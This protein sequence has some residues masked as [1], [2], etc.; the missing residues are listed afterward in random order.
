MQ[1]QIPRGPD[2]LYCPTWKKKMSTVCHT[3]PLWVRLAGKN[4]NTGE[5]MEGWH[6]SMQVGPILVLSQADQLR[7]VSNEIEALRNEIAKQIAAMTETQ[8]IATKHMTEN[9][10]AANVQMARALLEAIRETNGRRPVPLVAQDMDD[11]TQSNNH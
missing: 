4:P 11:G 6:C 9:I 8:L 5:D 10:R 3:C 7:S 1:T 2:N